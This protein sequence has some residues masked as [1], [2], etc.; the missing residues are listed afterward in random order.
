MNSLEYKTE[1]DMVLGFCQIIKNKGISFAVE[2]PYMNRSID[3]VLVEGGKTKAIEFKLSNWKK[4]IKQAKIHL[5]GADEVY[6]CLPYRQY[7]NRIDDIMPMLEEYGCGLYL[8]DSE[9]DRIEI[10]HSAKNHWHWC[11]GEKIMKRGFAYSLENQNYR[12]LTGNI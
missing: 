1:R 4:A 6:I 8:L 7:S 3:L 5:S 9:N 12:L 10:V 2:V 11:G